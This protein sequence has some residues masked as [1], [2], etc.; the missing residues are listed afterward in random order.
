VNYYNRHVGDYLKDTSHLTLLEH[1]IYSRLM[2]VYYVRESGLPQDQ[3]ARLIGARSKEEIS[4]LNSVLTEFFEL[5]SGIWVQ[6][7]CEK[8][9]EKFSDKSIKSKRSINTRWGNA[10]LPELG[11]TDDIRTYNE[12][13]TDD[14][15]TYNEGTTD[16][17]PRGRVPITN[18]Q[19]PITKKKNTSACAPPDG[20]TESVWKDF[21][22]HRKEKKARITQTAID[23]IQSEAAKAGWTLEAALR[24]CCAR[25]WTGFKAD[26][27]AE[28]K[29]PRASPAETPYQRSMREKMEQIAPS[30]AAKNPNVSQ[31]AVE[32]NPTTYFEN[33][34]KKRLE[35]SHA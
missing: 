25:G 24:E 20:V 12:G 10:K 19:T 17:I 22:Q 30:I 6:H 21:T 34:A 27:V 15:R 9:I 35:S 11:T 4:S 14:I 1:G 23:G 8:E 5:A 18:N 32:I 7:R 29:Q 16:D 28:N 26:W 13:T 2:D 31:R 3:V 33:L